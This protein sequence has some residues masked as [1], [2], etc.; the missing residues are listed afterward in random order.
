MGGGKLKLTKCEKNVVIFSNYGGKQ[1]FAPPTSIFLYM[2]IES[3]ILN[4]FNFFPQLTILL[5]IKI[6]NF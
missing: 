2:I 6:A 4:S 3:Y 5:S 1:T